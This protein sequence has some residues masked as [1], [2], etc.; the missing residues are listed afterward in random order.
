MSVAEIYE[1]GRSCGLLA[2]LL[3]NLTSV[4]A[5]DPT[6]SPTPAGAIAHQLVNVDTIYPKLLQEI[7]YAT[8]YNF[9]GNT[10]YPFPVVFL[11]RDAAAALRAVQEELLLEGL[12][13][14]IY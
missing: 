6:P 7:R 5:Q 3:M 9:T 12:G 14:K 11:H 4:M 1:R 8:T 2:M 13:L 10:L